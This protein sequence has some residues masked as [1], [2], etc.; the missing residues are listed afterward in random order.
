MNL[1]QDRMTSKERMEAL[2]NHR[3]PDR[4]PI[5]GLN[6]GFANRNAGYTVRSAYDNP[7]KT[8]EAQLWTAEQYGWELEPMWFAHTI[9]G[10]WDFGGIPKWPESEF[11]GA[12]MIET[13]PVEVLVD[14][15][16]V[17]PEEAVEKLQ[18]PDPR[19]AGGI[20]I[21]FEFAKLQEK[22][23]LPF[24]T[25]FPRAPMTS[26]ANI[27]GV[28]QFCRWIMKKPELCHKLLSSET[29]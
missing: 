17:S 2:W 5:S 19:T 10:G 28:E 9:L 13:P 26:A 15:L 24:V 4:V 12:L 3:K 22:N 8:F 14:K 11:Q 25:F 20:A 1:R 18:M 29:H 6:I 21:A 23:G 7:Q 27:C 16:N